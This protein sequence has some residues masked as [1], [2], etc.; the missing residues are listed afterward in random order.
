[1]GLGHQCQPTAPT[2]TA[3]R[4]AVHW[5][6]L[7]RL[8]W[9]REGVSALGAQGEIPWDQRRCSPAGPRLP[10]GADSFLP[11]AHVGVNGH[12]VVGSVS[13]LLLTHLGAA[14]GRELFS[15]RCRGPSI[16]TRGSN[17]YPEALLHP[18]TSHFP[19]AP[20]PRLQLRESTWHSAAGRGCW[21]RWTTQAARLW[22][23]SWGYGGTRDEEEL[24]GHRA[25]V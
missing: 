5:R 22:S 18:R 2:S 23:H 11:R 24:Q 1:M 9:S 20:L 14:G 25:A 3:P 4:G 21:S 12:T 16:M 6:F 17:L 10:P 13:E 7:L 19:D 8:R 15:T